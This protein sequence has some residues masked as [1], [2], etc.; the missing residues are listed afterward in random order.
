MGRNARLGAYLVGTPFAEVL[1]PPEPTPLDFAPAT[2]TPYWGYFLGSKGTQEPV[3]RPNGLCCCFIPVSQEI[4]L[5][6]DA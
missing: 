1:R 3:P 2:P 4:A 6:R 5:R